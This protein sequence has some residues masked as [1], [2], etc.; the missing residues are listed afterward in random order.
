MG[1]GYMIRGAVPYMCGTRAGVPHLYSVM[2]EH[3]MDRPIAFLD[4]LFEGSHV[5]SGGTA[6]TT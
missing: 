6:F 2:Y 3:V 4:T 5:S 1:A